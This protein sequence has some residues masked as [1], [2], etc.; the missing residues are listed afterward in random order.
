MEKEKWVPAIFWRYGKKYDFTGL[1]EVSNF[2]HL[3]S[4]DRI[5]KHRFGAQIKRGKQIKP[6]I[7]HN[8]Y[9]VFHL[10]K[11][12]KP[13][14]IVSQRLVWESFK[15]QIPDGYEINHIDEDKTNNNLSNLSLVTRTENCRWGTKSER[16]SKKMIN[17]KLS[18]TVL[19]FDVEGNLVKEWASLSEIKRELGYSIGNISIACRSEQKSNGFLW[20]YK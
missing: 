11:S 8:G 6:D 4:L 16:Q 13:I 17:G 20:R 19:Q 18:K 15:G 5:V 3:R 2:G 10:S 1:Y 9:C 14:K 7:I 12:N